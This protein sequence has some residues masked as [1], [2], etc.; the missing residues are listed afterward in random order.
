M[1]ERLYY[2]DSRL[3]EF[4]AH[5]IE[6]ADGGRRVYLD[7]TAFYPSSG[8]QPFDTGTLGG[9]TV[10]DVVDED[11]RIAHVLAKPLAGNQVH[12]EVDRERRFD[13]MQQHT[14]QHLLSA[15]FVEVLDAPTVSFHLGAE[16]STIDI[17]K[18]ALSPEEVWTVERR[19]NQIVWEARPVNISFEHASQATD[20]RKPTERE[21][22]I[23]IISIAGIDRSACGGTHMRSTSEIGPILI[24]RLERIRGNTRVEFVCGLRALDRAQRDYQALSAAARTF[25]IALDEVPARVTAQTAALQEAE[26]ARQKLA[27]ALA[28]TEGQQ[29][30]GEGKRLEVRAVPAIDDEVRALAQGFTAGGQ[31][32]FIATAENPPSVLLAVSADLGVHA[33][34]LLK[35]L[36]VEAGGRG[37]GNATLAQGSVPDAAKLTDLIARLT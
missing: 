16:A 15:V 27:T 28:R 31:A 8:G 5:I 22:E 26:K 32:R 12:G 25:S 19:A 35:P 33:G 14:G 6:S 10:V 4:D 36:L 1:T 23:R 34:N 18:A 24:R 37:G 20:L 13:H 2:H 9:V 11:E 17:A 30:Y 7:R 29:L 21:G 3:L